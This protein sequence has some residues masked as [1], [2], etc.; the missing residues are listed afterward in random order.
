MIDHL[1]SIAKVGLYAGILTIL[2]AHAATWL[3]RVTA[4]V[5]RAEASEAER[6]ASR[7]GLAAGAA[8]LACL[9]ARLWAHT[10]AAFGVAEAS[11]S[12]DKVWLIAFESRWGGAWRTQVVAATVSLLV[13]A[14][15]MRRSGVAPPL[16]ATLTSVA[17]VCS[18]PLM[19]HAA[20]HRL[21]AAVD[22]LHLLGGGAWLGT[23][24]VLVAMKPR[25]ALFER[26]S[27]LALSGAAIAALTGVVMAWLSLGSIANIWTTPYGRL[28]VAKVAVVLAVS[29]CGF[30]N[31]RRARA[32]QPPPA[33]GLELVLALTIV[34][35]TAF[36]TE[37]TPP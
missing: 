22:T 14:W 11:S 35:I 33:A 31:W 3:L 27:P 5:T 9:V 7:L 37:M 15:A 19:G 10:V 21:R 28:L 36:L 20:G 32:H 6:R 24:A 18:F 8:L 30:I 34:V 25:N 23:L 1:E 4:G 2:G 13:S 29:G 12:W 26:F 16:A 17:L